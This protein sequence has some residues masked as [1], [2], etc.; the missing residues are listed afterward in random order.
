MR[1]RVTQY[2]AGKDE[3]VTSAFLARRE[4]DKKTNLYSKHLHLLTFKN[5]FFVSTFTN[6]SSASHK[7]R[8]PNKANK[9]TAA[10][11]SVLF[12]KTTCGGLSTDKW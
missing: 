9:P 7:K 6:R 4:K 1:I 2:A 12:L 5:R 3:P 10:V 11:T 8:K